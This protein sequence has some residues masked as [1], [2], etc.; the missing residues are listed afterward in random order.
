MKTIYCVTGAAGHLGTAITKKLIENKMPTRILVLQNEKNIPHNYVEVFYGDVTQKDSLRPFLSHNSNERLLVIHCAGI[1]SIT[2]VYNQK[3]VDVNVTGTKNMVDLCLENKVDKLVYVSSVH[4]I[5]EKPMGEI[6]REVN[7]FDPKLVHGLYSK[8]KAEATEYALKATHLGLNVSVV[9]PSGIC[10]PY[11]YG[12]GHMTSL[13]ID[14]MKG[15]LVAG[16]KGGYDF[17]DVRDVAD[18]TIACAQFGR[19]NECY[20]LSNR[21]ISI[22]EILD[23]LQK[24]TGKPKVKVMLPQWFIKNTAVFAEF[25]YKLRK[26]SPLF[27]DYSIHVLGSNSNFSHQKATEELNYHTRDFK[28]TLVDTIN[29]LKENKRV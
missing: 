29:W 19:P 24:I 15:S 25:Y 4:A 3:V 27:T 11:D 13:V 28:E 5:P 16:M 1:V 9:H 22:S 6:I 2:S 12:K 23:L 20:I 14:Y 18:G 10:G 17:V 26:K 8:T 21:Y 7:Y